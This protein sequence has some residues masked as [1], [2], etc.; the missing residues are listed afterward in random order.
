MRRRIWYGSSLR[1]GMFAGSFLTGSSWIAARPRLNPLQ[2]ALLAL[3]G[4]VLWRR[5]CTGRVRGKGS[6]LNGC[7]LARTAEA[8]SLAFWPCALPLPLHYGFLFFGASIVESK[9]Q[10]DFTG[11]LASAVEAVPSVAL[12]ATRSDDG[13]ET[14]KCLSNQLGLLVVVEDGDF[15]LM[16]V[17]GVVDGEAQL[18]VP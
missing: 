12:A 18:L 17:G 16:V 14:H 9:L 1:R 13:L 15:E 2:P 8:D 10:A 6:A 11:I 4:R 7:A 5:R 3:L